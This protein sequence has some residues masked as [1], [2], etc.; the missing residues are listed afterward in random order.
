VSLRNHQINS[1]TFAAFKARKVSG[2]PV[3]QAESGA[4]DLAPGEKTTGV[5]SI[6]SSA[7]N[8]PQIYQLNFGADQSGPLKV[9]VV[10]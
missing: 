6:D 8:P 7:G 3:I 2:I 9:E 5:V 1:Q 4:R 10:L